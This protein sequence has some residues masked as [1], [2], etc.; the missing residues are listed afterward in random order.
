MRHSNKQEKVDSYTRGEAQTK[1]SVSSISQGDRAS[2]KNKRKG[3]SSVASVPGW[4]QKD[5]GKRLLHSES[6]VGK[7]S[8][9]PE[10]GPC[11]RPCP[12]V[13]SPATWPLLGHLER[14]NTP[15]I[16]PLPLDASGV[17]PD[18]P[19]HC[20]EPGPAEVPPPA[21]VDLGSVGSVLHR[22]QTAFQEALDLYHT[23]SQGAQGRMGQWRGRALCHCL[24]VL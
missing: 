3:V 10:D 9:G 22:L 24:R 1:I 12:A 14:Q 17:I 13:F 11:P 7:R 19:G 6:P 20:G 2:E 21:L 16:Y 23:V 5:L 4:Q 8:L 15:A 18:S